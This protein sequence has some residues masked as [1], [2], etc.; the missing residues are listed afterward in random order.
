MSTPPFFQSE[1]CGDVLVSGGKKGPTVVI[2]ESLSE[3]EKESWLKQTRTIHDWVV[4]CKSKK[5]AEEI[6]SFEFSGKEMFS[7]YGKRL[8]TVLT[9]RVEV[10]VICVQ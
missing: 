8:R 6:H 5:G 7:Q 10:D 2:W 1:G 3:Q 4:W 9:T